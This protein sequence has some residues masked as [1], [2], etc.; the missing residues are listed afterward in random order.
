LTVTRLCAPSARAFL[1]NKEK[2]RAAVYAQAAV[3]SDNAE[4]GQLLMS[5]FFC[6]SYW[7][8]LTPPP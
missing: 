1:E 5:V 2:G 6:Q 8:A 3:Y 4:L 7:S